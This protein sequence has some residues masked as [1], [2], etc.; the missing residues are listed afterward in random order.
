M[1]GEPAG[2][3]QE[4]AAANGRRQ[5][6][7]A[8]AGQVRLDHRMISYLGSKSSEPEGGLSH[9]WQ[10]PVRAEYN[11]TVFAGDSEGAPAGHGPGSTGRI[12]NPD[13]R[14]NHQRLMNG[15]VG[16]LMSRFRF[17][18][19][20]CTNSRASHIRKHFRHRFLFGL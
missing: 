14:L 13:N 18:M 7:M 10:S 17:E 20:D 1:N 6:H 12:H 8:A 2:P 19:R 3:P 11:L 5:R 9:R 4:W 15:D 16:S